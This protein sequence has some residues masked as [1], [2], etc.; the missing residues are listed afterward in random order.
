MIKPRFPAGFYGVELEGQGFAAL[1]DNDVQIRV[2]VVEQGF[3][4]QRLRTF[5]VDQINAA[6]RFFHAFHVFEQAV[7]VSVR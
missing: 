4:R 7:A 2:P 1:G 6:Q 5:R 3:E